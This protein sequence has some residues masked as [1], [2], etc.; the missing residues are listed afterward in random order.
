[1]NWVKH[2]LP[3]QS[4]VSLA[5]SRLNELGRG[6]RLL[7][8]PSFSPS[9]LRATTM[10]NDQSDETEEIPVEPSG[11]AL[12]EQ[13]QRQADGRSAAEKLWLE[14]LQRLQGKK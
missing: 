3:E 8:S 2:F 14:I 9:F 7:P 5:Q 12:T 4:S 13:R 11:K 6:W 10:P 1:L